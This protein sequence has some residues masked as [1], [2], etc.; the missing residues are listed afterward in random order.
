MMEQNHFEVLRPGINSTF[1][2]KGRFNVQYMGLAPGGAMD[3]QSFLLANIL[4]DN[5]KNTGA[6]EFAYQGPLL[7]LVKGKTKIVITGN[8]F[9]KIYS[10]NGEIIGDPYRTYDLNEGDQL[11]ILATKA[12]VYGYLSVEGG[13]K[14]DKFCGSVS[15]QPRAFI[16]P[17]EGKKIEFKD[18]ILILKNS[19]IK[20]NKIIRDIKFESKKIFSVLPG[21]QFHYFSTTSKKKFFSTPYM[22]TKQTDRMGMRVIGASLE[23]LINSN[24]PSEGIIKGAIQV[25][26]DGNPIILLSDHPT[27]GGYPKVGSIISSDYDDL[28]QQNANKEIFFQLVTLEAA[29]QQF[30]LYLEKIKKKISNIEEI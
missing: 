29:E 10:S 25:P 5:D 15:S 19:T 2:D 1:Q 13:F 27:T 28:I 26:G 4:L 21:P 11:D 14:L 6:I 17:N 23:N 12:S 16:G 8:V 20:K 30:A 9:F 24:I 18:K 3:Y 22:I 7:K